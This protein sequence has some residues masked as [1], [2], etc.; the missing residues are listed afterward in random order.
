MRLLV[1]FCHPS[2]N[3]YGA[4][5]LKTACRALRAAGHKLRVRDLYREGFNPVLSRGELK[6]YL[7]RTERIIARHPDHVADLRWAEGL[8]F[9]YP[10]WFYG[11]PAMLKGWLERVW[12]PGVAFEVAEERFRRPAG[13]LANIR[14][15]A[16]ITT[17]GSPWWWIRLIRDP[18]RSLITRGL[19]PLFSWRC[20]FIWRQLYDMNNQ[21]DKARADFLDRV[22]TTLKRIPV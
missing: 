5:L 14:L 2:A 8:V 4:A 18:G 20:R 1:V 11:P 13:L 6:D 10:T 17:S 21:T 15:V 3:S 19:R 22:E 16:C 7:P 12:L 9:I